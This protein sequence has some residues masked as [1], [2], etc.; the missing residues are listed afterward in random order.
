MKKVVMLL[1]AMV[2]FDTKTAWI[3]LSSNVVSIVKEKKLR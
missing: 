2:A 1:L 3:I